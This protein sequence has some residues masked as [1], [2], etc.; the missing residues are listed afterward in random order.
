MED[1]NTAD[2]SVCWQCFRVRVHV[3]AIAPFFPFEYRPFPILTNE[4]VVQ[5]VYLV[6]QSSP[7]VRSLL[8]LLYQRV[9]PNSM[10]P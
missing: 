10:N 3:Y 6:V 5:A 1:R 8:T 7:F 9:F 4:V 2:I